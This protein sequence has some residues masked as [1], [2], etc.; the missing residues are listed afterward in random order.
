MKKRFFLAALLALL[1]F[2][3]SAPEFGALKDARDGRTYKTV[4][5]GN[6]IWMAQNLDYGKFVRSN[7]P[8]QP[9][10]KYCYG[11]DSGACGERG[12]LYAWDAAM[13]WTK[14]KC[15][16]NDECRVRGICPKGW[17]LPNLKEWKR[18]IAAD[19]LCA[20][21]DSTCPDPDSL[22]IQCG[23]RE[24]HGA[25]KAESW[26][27]SNALGFSA[28]PA[29]FLRSD[30]DADEK[31][32][33]WTDSEANGRFKNSGAHAIF[34]TSSENDEFA[35]HSVLIGE[36]T[37]KPVPMANFDKQFGFSVRCVKD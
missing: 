31:R 25:L 21:S 9:A 19:S 11:N 20:S 12:G 32:K 22:G 36:D 23:Q 30:R 16:E 2:A 18:L 28:L 1:A 24:K 14:K 8:L 37:D 3:W 17:H 27:G 10:Q 33:E 15:G 7:K 35:A 26:N 6:Q 5:I 13:A 34:W 29:G 4:K